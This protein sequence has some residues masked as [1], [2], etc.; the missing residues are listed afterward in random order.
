MLTLFFAVCFLGLILFARKTIP[1]NP[2]F[3]VALLALVLLLAWGGLSFAADMIPAHAPAVDASA[4]AALADVLRQS[5][6]PILGALL[7]GILTPLINRLGVKFKIDALTQQNNLLE[8]AALQGISYAEERAAQ[9]VGSKLSLTNS[10]KLDIAISHVLSVMPRV[11]HEQADTMVHSLLAQIPGMGA[12]GSAVVASPGTVLA[13]GP[14]APPST[15]AIAVQIPG[16]QIASVAAAPASD[17]APAYTVSA[18]SLSAAP[19]A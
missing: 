6:F 13:S 2:P 17:A 10:N 18:A 16:A 12:T 9:L 15:A 5:V 8:R 7:M 14:S 3:H 19:A 11:T 1:L 4:P